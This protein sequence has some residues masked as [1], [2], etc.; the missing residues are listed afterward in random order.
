[1]PLAMRTDVIDQTLAI[2]VHP[3]YDCKTAIVSASMILCLAQSL[4]A[5]TYI[6]RKEVIENMLQMCELKQKIVSEQLSQSYQGEKEDP[7]AVNALKYV[8]IPPLSLSLSLSLSLALTITHFFPHSGAT[9][10]L[11]W[12]KLDLVHQISPFHLTF[13]LKFST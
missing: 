12:L 8:I 13:S 5:H 3:A 7:M 4:E 6:A 2:A 11:C 9:L 1:M 10:V